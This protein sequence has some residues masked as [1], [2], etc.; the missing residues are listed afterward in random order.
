M[1][2]VIVRHM[3]TLKVHLMDVNGHISMLKFTGFQRSCLIACL[4]IRH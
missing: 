1:V 3:S 4:R 2:T